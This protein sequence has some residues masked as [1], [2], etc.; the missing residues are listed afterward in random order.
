MIAYLRATL[1][2]SRATK[3]PLAAEFERLRDY[4]ELMSVR[5]GPRL[6][7]EL[8]LP[9][10]VAGI[11]V[12]TLL[13]QPLVENSIR[14]GLEPKVEGGRIRVSAQRAGGQ[15]LIEVSDTGVG[16]VAMPGERKGFGLVQVRER[17]A[18]LYGDAARF[19]FETA[20]GAGARTR[21]S[22][23]TPA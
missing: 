1:D 3:H 17:L 12:P 18:A 21:I 6:A 5:M 16:Q 15:L 10:E 7:Y 23:P 20:P 19:E 8:E 14:H 13:L 4:L 9:P 2:A 22:L 11:A